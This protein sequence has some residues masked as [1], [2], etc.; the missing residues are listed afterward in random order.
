MAVAWV[1]GRPAG[2]LAAAAGGTTVALGK[3]RSPTATPRPLATTHVAAA[4]KARG[5]GRLATPFLAVAP[6]AP[7]RWLPTQPR[8]WRRQEGRR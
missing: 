2:P 1:V 8:G 5:G 3:G 4:A 6:A 7:R